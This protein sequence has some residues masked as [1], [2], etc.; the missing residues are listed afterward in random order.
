MDKESFQET[1]KTKF[2]KARILVLVKIYVTKLPPKT[3]KRVNDES[4]RIKIEYTLT[5]L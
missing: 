2:R 3:K 1:T 5:H 4:E